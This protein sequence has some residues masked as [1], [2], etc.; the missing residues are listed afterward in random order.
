MVVNA[1]DNRSLLS[2]H[3]TLFYKHN[4]T[5]HYTVGTQF[6]PSSDLCRPKKTSTISRLITLDAGNSWRGAINTKACSPAAFIQ[7]FNLLNEHCWVVLVFLLISSSLP[8]NLNSLWW[9]FASYCFRSQKRS[10]DD[11]MCY[12]LHFDA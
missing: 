9:S 11:T 2:M 8:K 3:C 4:C 1:E 7:Q 12:K 10:K 5:C 6:Y